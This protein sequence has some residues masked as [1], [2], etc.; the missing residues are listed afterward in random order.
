MTTITVSPSMCVAASDAALRLGIALPAS[1]ADE[2]IKAALTAAPAVTLPAP[3][4]P[5]GAQTAFAEARAALEET[6]HFASTSPGSQDNINLVLDKLDELES[7]L[8]AVSGN[9]CL[10]KLRPGEPFFVLLGRDRNAAEAVRCWAGLREADRGASD[11][12]DDARQI[13][14]RMD[15]YR[16]DG[17]SS[18]ALS[19]SPDDLTEKAKRIAWALQSADTPPMWDD[20]HEMWEDM[21]RAAKAAYL[22]AARASSSQENLT[23]AGQG[24]RSPTPVRCSQ[25]GW[26]G[27]ATELGAEG[28][29]GGEGCPGTAVSEISTPADMIDAW[30]DSEGHIC[31]PQLAEAGL[32]AQ[33]PASAE[34]AKHLDIQPGDSVWD[35]TDAGKTVLDAAR[36]EGA[37]DGL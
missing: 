32:I 13:A 11:R 34:E 33:H 27:D 8:S 17:V 21:S 7:I 24:A 15:A 22:A 30:Q 20:A 3:T 19:T 18:A 25:C 31:G 5:E 23:A 2:I 28:E 36:G 12:V 14:G 1:Q 35:L 29:C 16:G 6:Y 10:Q 26:L 9:P 37:S 4:L